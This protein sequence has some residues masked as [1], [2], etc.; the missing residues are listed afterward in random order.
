MGYNKLSL[1]L[2]RGIIGN[3]VLYT[4]YSLYMTNREKKNYM[5][6]AVS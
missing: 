6:F 5:K 1:S 2:G 4:L 3:I